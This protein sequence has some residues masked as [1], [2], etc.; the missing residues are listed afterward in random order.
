MASEGLAR[1]I[2]FEKIMPGTVGGV[3]HKDIPYDRPFGKSAV[4][5]FYQI[6]L[7]SRLCLFFESFQ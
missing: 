1:N 4:L 2:R 6:R 3:R 7:R 5:A